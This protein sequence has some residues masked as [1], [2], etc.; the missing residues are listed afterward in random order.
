MNEDDARDLAIRIVDEMVQEGI[1]KNC[2]DTND[3]DEF[4]AQ[5]IIVKWIK[6]L[7]QP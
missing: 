4:T 3:Q 5:D 7:N 1:V 2:I 6:N